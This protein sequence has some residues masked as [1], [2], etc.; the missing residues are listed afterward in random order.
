MNEDTNQDILKELRRLRR[1]SQLSVFCTYLAFGLVAVYM[2]FSRPQ[3][4]R[5]KFARNLEVYSR[6]E[7]APMESEDPWT[8]ADAA[9]IQGDN[10]KAL[11]IAKA[12]CSPITITRTLFWGVFM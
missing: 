1:S 3:S 8:R 9:L 6:E 4:S 12:H 5:S 2:A 10:K 7:R 11:S